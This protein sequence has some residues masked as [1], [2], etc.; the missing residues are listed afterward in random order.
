MDTPEGRIHTSRLNSFSGTN[1][2]PR[3]PLEF[4]FVLENFPSCQLVE[5]FGNRA[6]FAVPNDGVQSIS[7]TFATLDNLKTSHNVE[8]Y[9]F[10]QTTLEQV[11]I[12]F[13]KEND[14]NEEH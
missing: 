9:S 6:T 14:E 12:T 11:F 2:S 4:Q 13:A 7:K 1:E 5:A 3:V 10:S 8:E